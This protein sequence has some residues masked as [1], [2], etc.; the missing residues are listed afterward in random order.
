MAAPLMFSRNAVFSKPAFEATLNDISGISEQSLPGIR[1]LIVIYRNGAV[2]ILRQKEEMCPRWGPGWQ[3]TTWKP[4][5]GEELPRRF[6]P[7]GK[8]MKF[9]SP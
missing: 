6:N 8:P 9:L 4:Y 7:S 5:R 2:R 3:E 1:S